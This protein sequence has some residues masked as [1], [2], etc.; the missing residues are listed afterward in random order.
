MST[1]VLFP[2]IAPPVLDIVWFGWVECLFQND[3][4]VVLKLFIFHFQLAILSGLG[5]ERQSSALYIIVMFALEPSLNAF[6]MFWH[7]KS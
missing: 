2:S 3:E 7:E 1:I 4:A 6:I 5:I